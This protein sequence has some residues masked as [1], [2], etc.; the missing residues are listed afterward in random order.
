MTPTEIATLQA[1]NA[2]LRQQ[3]I[4]LTEQVERLTTEL[5]RTNTVSIKQAVIAYGA[6]C[7]VCGTGSE[8]TTAW[9]EICEKLPSAHSKGEPAPS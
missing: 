5:G 2:R 6:A 9:N 1:D 4:G 8:V 3:V 7:R